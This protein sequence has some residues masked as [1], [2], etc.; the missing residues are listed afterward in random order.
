MTTDHIY[1]PFTAEQ[2][3]TLNHYQHS[4]HF[5]PFTCGRCRDKLGTGAWPHQPYQGPHDDRLLVATLNGWICPTCDYTQDW[6]HAFM[7]AADAPWMQPGYAG[8]LG[9]R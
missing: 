8:P 4:G 1:A 5:H 2:V 9:V 3:T 7:A 6:A